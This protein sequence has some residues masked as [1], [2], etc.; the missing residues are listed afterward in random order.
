MTPR[1]GT[2]GIERLGTLLRLYVAE[3]RRLR[4]ERAARHVPIFM[5]DL[6]A[7]AV[8][9]DATTPSETRK[10]VPGGDPRRAD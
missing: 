10:G 9:S 2:S 6:D 4:A 7:L 5:D 8:V 3:R 1:P